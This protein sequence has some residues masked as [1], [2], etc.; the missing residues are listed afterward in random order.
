MAQA[1]A[2][3]PA[4][5]ARVAF[6]PADRLERERAKSLTTFGSGHDFLSTDRTAE[7]LFRR[8]NFCHGRAALSFR[9]FAGNVADFILLRRHASAVAADVLLFRGHDLDF[10]RARVLRFLSRAHDF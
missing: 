2:Q 6:A 7:F 5:G 8:A 4:W 9:E 3:S 1:F 10:V